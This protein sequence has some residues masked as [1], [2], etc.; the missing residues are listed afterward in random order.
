MV[1]VEV[2]GIS[3]MKFDC[4]LDSNVFYGCCLHFRESLGR[5]DA[6]FP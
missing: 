1:D 5:S 2:K 3:R 4:S 6:K